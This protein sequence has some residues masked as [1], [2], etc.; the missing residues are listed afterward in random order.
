MS[1]CIKWEVSAGS[2]LNMVVLVVA[3]AGAWGVMAER[4][5]HTREGMD[6]LT[7]NLSLAAAARRLRVWRVS[8]ARVL[9][10]AS[11][12]PKRSMAAGEMAVAGRTIRTALPARRLDLAVAGA[13]AV[14]ARSVRAVAVQMASW[15]CATRAET[16]PFSLAGPALRAPGSGRGLSSLR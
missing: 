14:A 1:E 8:A 6:A 10:A 15:W 5:Q 7:R 11:P 9:P 13:A 4:G 12:G 3:V 2:L 16:L